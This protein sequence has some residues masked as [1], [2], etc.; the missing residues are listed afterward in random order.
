ML[1]LLFAAALLA[2][3]RPG[4]GQSASGEARKVPVSTERPTLFHGGRILLNDG[5]GTAVQALLARAGKIVAVG[6]LAEVE[7][8]PEAKDAVRV[9]LAGA[10]AVPGLQDAH[11]HLVSYGASLVNVDLRGCASFEEVIARVVE[12]AGH[13]KEGAWILGRG[14]DQNLWPEKTFP[15]HAKLSEKT[16]KNP[17]FLTRVDGHA[18]IANR[19][20]L[21]AAK[22]DHEFVDEPRIQGGRLLLDGEGRPTGVLVDQAMDLVQKN[23]PDPGRA[24]TEARILGAQEK[25]LPYGLTC[26]HDMGTTRVQLDILED[27][28][29]RGK[30]RLRVVAYLAG[31][32]DLTDEMLKGLPLAPDEKDL[33]CCPGVKLIADGALGSR[34][35]ALLEDYSDAPG[36]RG[37]LI[38]D[39]K[40]LS[41]KVALCQ[42]HGLQ[43]AIHAIG[44]RANR[45][46]LDIFETLMTVYPNAR[47][48]RP[49]IE[50]AQIVSLK[51][52]PRFPALG[53]I[54]SMQPVHAISDMP[55]AVDR[56][57]KERARRAYAWRALAPELRPLAFGSDFPVE[58]PDPLPGLYAARMR[59]N[60]AGGPD[61]TLSA[62]QRLDGASAL[63]G[64]TSGAAYACHQENRRGRLLP[65]FACDLTV[66]SVDPVACDPAALL[67]AHVAMTVINGEI[68]WRAK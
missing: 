62:D 55:W 63:A 57:G 59:S 53:V 12:R 47:E 64:F 49:R 1:S 19:L 37:L 17:V 66:L 35:A 18:A 33:L 40:Q 68:V 15:R 44:D 14:W 39:E 48:L 32:D 6:A 2:S 7:G 8:F 54:P 34:G 5:K 30:L 13:E 27:L 4:D 28:R 45:L 58:S 3:V 36:E 24:A 23:I 20:A 52:W 21:A 22:L 31:T 29:A 60:P 26:V 50:H 46:V 11:G 51:D 41:T 67:S 56:L 43:P 9:D 16:P 42:S 10:T 25:L 38:L 65:G 61:A